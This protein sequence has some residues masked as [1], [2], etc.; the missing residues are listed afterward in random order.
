MTRESFMINGD[1]PRKT[2]VNQPFELFEGRN[3][4]DRADTGTEGKTK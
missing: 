1:T 4:K 3:A 2:V